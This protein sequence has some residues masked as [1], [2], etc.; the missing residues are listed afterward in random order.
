MADSKGNPITDGASGKPGNIVFRHTKGGRTIMCKKPDFSNRQFSQDQL[1]HQEDRKRQLY[2]K[3]FHGGPMWLR[4]FCRPNRKATTIRKMVPQDAV[5]R[6]TLPARPLH[7]CMDQA[8][9]RRD[10]AE[11]RMDVTR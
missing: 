10:L 2:E 11:V 7:P 9:Q 4:A 1:N 6:Q 3:G 5:I 8:E